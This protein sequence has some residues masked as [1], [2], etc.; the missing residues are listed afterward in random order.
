M[1]K[2][3]NTKKIKAKDAL[4]KQE[5]FIANRV[6]AVFAGAAVMLWGW[7]IDKRKKTA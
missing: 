4:R 7:Y 3:Q 1:N 2:E 5:D 6:M